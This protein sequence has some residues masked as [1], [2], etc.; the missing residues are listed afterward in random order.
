MDESW[1]RLI[2]VVRIVELVEH[3]FFNCMLAQQ[4]WRYVANNIFA[5]L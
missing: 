1:Q 4:A 3:M 5:T 2:K